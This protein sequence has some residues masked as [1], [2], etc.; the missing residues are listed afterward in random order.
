MT[1]PRSDRETSSESTAG[2]D[3]ATRQDDTATDGQDEALSGLGEIMAEETGEETGEEVGEEVG[4][5]VAE[6]EVEG[7]EDILRRERDL[8]QEKWLRS[9]AEMENVRKRSRRELLESRRFA[10]AD[11]LRPYL[12]V[13]DN[14]ERALQTSPGKPDNQKHDGFREG[15]ELIYQRFQ[16]LF[17]DLG[18]EPIEALDKPF[19]PN[20][21][22]AVGQLE[23]EGTASGLVIEVVQ[24]GY[25]FQEL[26]L[27]PARVIIAG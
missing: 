2:P 23:R 8:F 15:I 26:V 25:Q 13:L 11:V 17:K 1:K 20:V 3:E 18:V 5:D 24:Q 7:P 14:F 12:D 27:R 6:E 16:G 19:D 4:E 21:H 22:E 9:A 10:Q